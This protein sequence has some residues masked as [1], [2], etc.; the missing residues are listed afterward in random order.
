MCE[1][2]SK[3]EGYILENVPICSAAKI[4]VD[5]TVLLAFSR[6]FAFNYVIHIIR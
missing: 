4:Q 2:V 3:L 5:Y 1:Y 6:R